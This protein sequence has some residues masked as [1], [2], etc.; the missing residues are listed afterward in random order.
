MADCGDGCAGRSS[1]VLEGLPRVTDHSGQCIGYV[2]GETTVVHNAN[3]LAALVLCEAAATPGTAPTQADA[4]AW[5]DEALACARFTAARQTA[6]GSWPYSEESYGRWVDGF[7]TGF[8]LEGLASVVRATGDEALRA[9]LLPAACASTSPNS[10]ARRAS[11]STTPTGRI[12][13]TLFRRR[14]ASRHSAARCAAPGSSP[15]PPRPC[16]DNWSGSRR[17]YCGPDGRVAYQVHRRWTD[18]R[19]F[20]RWASA[21][22]MSALAGVPPESLCEQLTESRTHSCT[23]SR[24]DSGTAL[25]YSSGKTCATDSEVDRAHD[26]RPGRAPGRGHSRVPGRA[27]GRAPPRARRRPVWIDLANSPHVLFFQPVIA[28]LHRRGVPTVVS[29]RDFAQTVELCRLWGLDAEVVGAHGGA[30]LVG[31]AGNLA[32]RVRALRAF[33]RTHRPAVAVSHNSYAQALAAR[34][35]GIPVVTAMDYEFQPANHLAFRCATLVAVPDV[36]PLDM[37]RRQ[38]AKPGQSLALLRP[39]GADRPGGLR[40]RSR[41][42][43]TRGCREAETACRWWSSVRRPTWPSI[44]ASRTR[45]SPSCSPALAQRQSRGEVRVLLL[46]RTTAQAAALEG[47]GY[48][49]LLWTGEALDGRQ[50]VAAA[51]AVISAGGSMNREAAVLGHACLLHIRGQAGSH[52]PGLGGRRPAPIAADPRRRIGPGHQQ[53]AV[54]GQLLGG[55]RT[56]RAVR[57]QGPPGGRALSRVRGVRVCGLFACD[58][59]V[60]ASSLIS[61]S[62]FCPD[63]PRRASTVNVPFVDLK[64]QG[65][66]LLPEYQAALASIVGRAA[67]IMG[68]ELR[69]FEAA[70]AQFCTTQHAVGVSSGT[71]A[72]VLAYKAVGVGPGDEVI[73]PA[74][75]FMAT[76]EAVTHVG[77]TPV[78]VDVLP[79]TANID[80][81][82]VEAAVTPRT[83]AIVPVHLFGQPA[84]MDAINAIAKKHGLAVVEDAC[85]AH[86]ATYKGRVAGS[87]GDIAAFSFYPGKNLGAL[88][89][90]GAVTTSD[91]DMAETCRVLRNHGEKSKSNHTVVGY[92]FRLDNLQAAFL[93]IKLGHLAEWTKARRAAAKRYDSLLAEITGKDGAPAVAPITESPD[94][95]AVYHLYVV[96]VDDRDAVRAK[97]DE[98]GVGTGIHYPVPIHLHAAYAHLGYKKGAF[99]VAERLAERILSLPMFPEITEGQIDYVV[100]QLRDAVRI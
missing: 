42:S 82:A 57:R 25:S 22:L 14:R 27:P 43:G 84:D 20:P 93:Q 72:L 11:P 33:A 69:D 73:L 59:L 60:F 64:T 37:L 87:L 6:D 50:L 85:Q 80:P 52:R 62:L 48:G 47:Q 65:E 78:V 34:T 53:K 54:T 7:H 96:Q 83:K 12:P 68:P 97:L 61:R 58:Q 63:K 8:V 5:L 98:A 91:A 76:A 29:A 10:S 66:R 15:G 28:E 71:D 86:G 70:F 94:V 18:R 1:F 79:D 36:Y 81:A 38:G 26:F 89:D 67:Y 3:M 88:G 51:D 9:T 39:Q 19:E 41:L 31:K 17:T 4:D 56:S 16:Q 13:S 44:T 95:Q 30:G 75:T 35:L 21:P 45:C 55:R 49:E 24:T 99:P 90:G 77:G 74:N 32:G 40:A 100:E 23:E 2:P 46:A 92:C